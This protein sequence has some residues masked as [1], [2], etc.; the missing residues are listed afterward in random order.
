M[1]PTSPI[2]LLL[3]LEQSP[4]HQEF[5]FLHL[6]GWLL[7]AET[8]KPDIYNL[9]EERFI[10]LIVCRGF[11]P[12]S[13]A[14]KQVVGQRCITEEEQPMAG[15]RQQQGAS[16]EPL[17]VPCILGGLLTLWTGSAQAPHPSS[18]RSRPSHQ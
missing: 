4:L 14:P 7:I 8:K 17:S 2:L 18:T 1:L 3:L 5:I 11:S 6:R 15:R 16:E 12:Q 9:K 10:C 13:A